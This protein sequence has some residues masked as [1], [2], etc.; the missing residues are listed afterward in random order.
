MQGKFVL[1]QSAS[2][3]LFLKRFSMQAI[4][5]LGIAERQPVSSRQKMKKERGAKV[6]KT[7]APRCLLRPLL[8]QGE[9]RLALAGD[10]H[11]LGLILRAFVPRGDRVAAVGNV[12]DLVAPGLV[13]YREVG[14]G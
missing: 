12:V 8:A 7:V 4:S 2:T 6:I 5:S 9:I 1:S 10:C 11:R 13:R 14:S 3:F